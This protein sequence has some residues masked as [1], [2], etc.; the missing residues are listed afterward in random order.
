MQISCV[1]EGEAPLPRL[2]LLRA[3]ITRRALS[4]MSTPEYN[5]RAASC[6][7]PLVYE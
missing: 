6:V 7:L 4:G 1:G 5:T 2:L 3:V